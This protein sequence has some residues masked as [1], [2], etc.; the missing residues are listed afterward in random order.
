MVR[1][2]MRA[3]AYVVVT[4]GYLQR[5]RFEQL[6]WQQDLVHDAP[7]T[8]PGRIWILRVIPVHSLA[9]RLPDGVVFFVS[10]GEKLHHVGG[11]LA[12]LEVA[13]RI[14]CLLCWFHAPTI[15]PCQELLC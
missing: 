3:V 8:S 15:D 6:R 9:L 10:L 4:S 1:C 14:G 13:W 12:P 2:G 7:E 5:I 11:N